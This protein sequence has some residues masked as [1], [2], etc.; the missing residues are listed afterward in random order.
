MYCIENNCTYRAPHCE[1]TEINKANCK[2]PDIAIKT[3][4]ILTTLQKGLDKTNHGF[5]HCEE[6]RQN[7]SWVSSLVTDGLVPVGR[8]QTLDALHVVADGILPLGRV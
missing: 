4:H 3:G 7:K 5:P 6:A 8:A 2:Q 1:T